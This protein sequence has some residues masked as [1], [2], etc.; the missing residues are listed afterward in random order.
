MLWPVLVLDKIIPGLLPLM[1]GNGAE[2]TEVI[3]SVCKDWY[4]KYF[5]IRKSYCK[6]L[7]L[8]AAFHYSN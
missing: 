4:E 7:D 5:K 3:R 1:R 8:L 2:V 6:I